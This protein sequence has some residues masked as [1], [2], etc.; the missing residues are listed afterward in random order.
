[1]YRV[2]I[3]LPGINRE[4]GPNP[5]Q[6]LSLTQTQPKKK[7]QLFAKITLKFTLKSYPD[8]NQHLRLISR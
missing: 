5:T 2:D 8:L 3:P 7:N 4:H 1:M 6:T